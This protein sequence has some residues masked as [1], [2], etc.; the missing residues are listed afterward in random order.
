MLVDENVQDSFVELVVTRSVTVLLKPFR[1]ATL[2]VEFPLSPEFTVTMVG[3]A[4]NMKSG[5][6]VMW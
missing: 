6:L 1:G 2:I 3:L 5:A 4:V